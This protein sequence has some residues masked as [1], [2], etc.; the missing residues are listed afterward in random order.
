MNKATLD[1]L[2]AG[3]KVCLEANNNFPVHDTSIPF[4]E[5]VNTFASIIDTLGT[6]LIKKGWV[7]NLIQ[8][9]HTLGPSNPLVFVAGPVFP[10]M[11]STEWN[12]HYEQGD[13]E[14]ETTRVIKFLK[15]AGIP[16][17]DASTTKRPI[18]AI[19][20]SD[21]YLRKPRDFE[22][23]TKIAK[24]ESAR[25][26]MCESTELAAGYMKGPALEK[27]DNF[28]HQLLAEYKA[29]DRRLQVAKYILE[30]LKTQVDN[31]EYAGRISL[32][33]Y[34]A[35]KYNFFERD[36]NR[37]VEMLNAAGIRTEVGRAPKAFVVDVNFQDEADERE[38]DA[39]LV[40]ELRAAVKETGEP[41][42]AI[43]SIISKLTNGT[44][45]WLKGA[46]GIGLQNDDYKAQ[47]PALVKFI[48]VASRH[49]LNVSMTPRKFGEYILIE[50]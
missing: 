42:P 41:V 38:K 2:R 1:A 28:E 8:R 15:Q 30:E 45:H 33:I 50:W 19:A 37:V 22:Y 49:G 11:P 24:L 17:L 35:S 39:A 43:D 9:L 20:I 12:K 44:A 18:L 31:C 4:D 26:P 47:K 6:G 36:L 32:P 16:A 23:C 7:E 46:A 40:A 5:R 21:E 14:R 10:F 29:D 25:I 34:S 13:F 27:I 48:E 3:Y